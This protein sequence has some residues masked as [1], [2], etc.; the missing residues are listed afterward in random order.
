[1]LR[2]KDADFKKISLQINIIC[3]LTGLILILV[4]K[5]A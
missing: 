5:Q 2:G 1:M 4:E 3:S